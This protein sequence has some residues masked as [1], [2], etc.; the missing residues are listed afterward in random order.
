V[1]E[2]R[3][4]REARGGDLHWLRQRHADAD[5]SELIAH[6]ASVEYAET[7]AVQCGYRVVGTRYAAAGEWENE[8]G[9]LLDHFEAGNPGR[10]DEHDRRLAWYS[11]DR[12]TVM[13]QNFDIDIAI[14]PGA[15]G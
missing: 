8:I 9:H 1:A 3:S 14:V 7:T 13:K 10:R 4:V 6:T 2:G 15:G 11:F 12:Q 5:L